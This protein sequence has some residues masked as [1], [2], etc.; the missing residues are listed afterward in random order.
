[1]STSESNHLK[2]S[3]ID[4]DIKESV[5]ELESVISKTIENNNKNLEEIEQLLHAKNAHI[6]PLVESSAGHDHE[7]IEIAS[8]KPSSTVDFGVVDDVA[9]NGGNVESV[10]VDANEEA[11]ATT[12]V[13]SS[14]EVAVETST[15]TLA[16]IATETVTPTMQTV[17]PTTLRP[18]IDTTVSTRLT[19]FTAKVSLPLHLYNLT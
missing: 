8:K 19:T 7:S 18:D 2:P 12:S 6:S 4:A 1:M 14:T 15:M 13:M 11:F 10:A 3:D 16:E 17:V 5:S 9:K